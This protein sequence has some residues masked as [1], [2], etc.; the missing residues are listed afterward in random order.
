MR[1][2]LMFDMQMLTFHMFS[3]LQSECPE[4][5]ENNQNLMVILKF[6][7]RLNIRLFGG[8]TKYLHPTC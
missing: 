2:F 3:V 1:I 7:L 8:C 6:D 4:Q 5:N